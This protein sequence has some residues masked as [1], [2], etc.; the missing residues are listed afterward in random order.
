MLG[1]VSAT[2]DLPLIL[3]HLKR[4]KTFCPSIQSVGGSVDWHQKPLQPTPRPSMSPFFISVPKGGGGGQNGSAWL[5]DFAQSAF[6]LEQCTSVP[7]K[8]K[9]PCDI[10]FQSTRFQ[11]VGDY[12]TL[13]EA[14]L[15]FFDVQSCKAAGNGSVVMVQ[16]R[17]LEIKFCNF[18]VSTLYNL[19]DCT[20]S[21][22]VIS[23]GKPYTMAIHD[24]TLIFMVRSNFFTR[25]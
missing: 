25:R 7:Y 9:T 6:D 19:F 21:L 15:A 14:L 3:S 22:V 12:Y 18:R 11:W 16:L 13:Y 4:K 8:N 10:S 17:M 20:E 24:W 5:W 23:N 2:F 1:W